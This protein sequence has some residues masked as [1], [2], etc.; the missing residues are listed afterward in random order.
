MRPGTLRFVVAAVV[1]WLGL[2]LASAA[3]GPDYK[4]IVHPDNPVTEVDR[5]FLRDAY[6]RKASVWDSGEPIRPIDLAARFPVRERFAQDVL[7]KNPS[8]LRNYWNQQIFSGK[9]VP[10]PEADSP[11][12]VVAYVLANPGAIGYLPVDTDTG[13]ARVVGVK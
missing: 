5:A 3:G 10:P 9:G 11:A 2:V 8:Q 6:L 4:V 12:S 13:R 1:S 7:R